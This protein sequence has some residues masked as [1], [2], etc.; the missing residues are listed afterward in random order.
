MYCVCQTGTVCSD[1]VLLEACTM[2]EQHYVICVLVR[3]DN[4]PVCVLQHSNVHAHVCNRCTSGAGSE[5]D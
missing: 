4:T 2:E 5:K 1:A 3:E